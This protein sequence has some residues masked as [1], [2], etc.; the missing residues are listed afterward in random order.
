M[1]CMQDCTLASRAEQTQARVREALKDKTIN[2]GARPN[3]LRRNY[4]E[5]CW[6]GAQACFEEL[7]VDIVY[8]AV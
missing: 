7:L 5:S 8:C 4:L 1:H 6:L 3:M 2:A